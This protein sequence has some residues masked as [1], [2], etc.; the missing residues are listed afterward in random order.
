MMMM[1]SAKLSSHKM[2]RVRLIAIA[3]KQRFA[4]HLN[5]KWQGR[6]NTDHRVAGDSW[7]FR[8]ASSLQKSME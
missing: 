5:E 3:T 1:M 6:T 8:L 7:Y 2:L 4:I